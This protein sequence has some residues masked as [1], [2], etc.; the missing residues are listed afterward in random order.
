MRQAVLHHGRGQQPRHRGR[1]PGAGRS[2]IPAG[3]QTVEQAGALFRVDHRSWWKEELPSQE[4][5]Q[6]AR[7]TLEQ[8]GW[9][10]DYILTHCCPTSVQD[11]FSGGLYQHDELTDFFDEDM[12]RCQFKYWFFGHYHGNMVVEKKFAMLYEQIIK[13]KM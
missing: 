7:A 10:T 4:E 1:D 3:I 2:P 13:L 5:Y 9:E 12:H 6:T 8:N 11:V